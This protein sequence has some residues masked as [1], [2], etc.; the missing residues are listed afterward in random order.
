M[1]KIGRR[2]RFTAVVVTASCL[3]AVYAAYAHRVIPGLSG[4]G[5]T[6]TR[7]V[8]FFKSDEQWKA[9]LTPEQYRVTR[10]QGTE[11][12]FS[13]VYH[14]SKT[15]G[16]YRCVCCDA[17]LFRSEAKF[18]SG[19][20]WPSFWEPVHE[21]SITS[22]RE[23]YLMRGREVR[24]QRCDAH[25]GHVFNDGPPPTGLRYCINSVALKLDETR[26]DKSP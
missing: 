18:D 25:L 3:L 1:T 9:R 22:A 6:T 2:A 15:P 13:G 5:P 11:R 26:A 23:G 19:T 16:L 21:E 4:Y 7:E 17:P 20:G 14:D 12:A 10:R 24:C 8:P